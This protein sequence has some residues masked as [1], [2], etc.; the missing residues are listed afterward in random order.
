MI[1]WEFCRLFAAVQRSMRHT[2]HKPI[3]GR[4]T[5]D[6]KP[7]GERCGHVK[8][9]Y[10]R[11]HVLRRWRVCN[12]FFPSRGGKA[13]SQQGVIWQRSICPNSGIGRQGWL[14]GGFA[15]A[16]KTDKSRSVGRPDRRQ[17]DQLFDAFFDNCLIRSW[18][19][20][21]EFGPGLARDRK[22]VSDVN[23]GAV[24]GAGLSMS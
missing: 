17:N 23:L 21:K 24:S 2:P 16:G 19:C 15:D 9:R 7:P 18:I 14:A 4:Y 1:T 22:A 5:K 20:R 12:T 3:T 8:G 6:A 13:L 10:E 11:R